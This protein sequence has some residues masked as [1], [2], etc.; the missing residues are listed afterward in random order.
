MKKDSVSL[1]SVQI[2]QAFCVLFGVSVRTRESVGV[3]S[4][5]HRDGNTSMGIWP[6]K[7]AEADAMMGYSG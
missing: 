1:R 6:H 5:S 3:V 7:L 2:L 4:S